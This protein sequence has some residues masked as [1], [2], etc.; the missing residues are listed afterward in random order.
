MKAK[1]DLLFIMLAALS[2]RKWWTFLS[3]SKDFRTLII[4]AAMA[5]PVW[6]SLNFEQ[7]E[8]LITEY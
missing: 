7:A 1:E 4:L 6:L 5:E 8:K 2:D 3:I